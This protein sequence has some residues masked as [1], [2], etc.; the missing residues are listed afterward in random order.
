MGEDP[1]ISIVDDDPSVARALAR[2]CRSGGYSVLS[3]ES[4]EAFLEGNGPAQTDCL[5]LDVH[6]PGQSGPELQTHLMDVGQLVPI[7]FITAFEGERLRDEALES[8]ARAFF[9]KPLDSARL[10][11]A[12]RDVLA[13]A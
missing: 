1:R 12:I 8:G 4:A 10:L 9:R 2:L 5:I 13:G 11:D 3:F 7:I 6:L